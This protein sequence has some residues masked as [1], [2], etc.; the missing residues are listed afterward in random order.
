MAA[1]GNDLY[2]TPPLAVEA[3]LRAETLPQRLWEPACG[4]G[5]MVRA[6]RG[7]GFSVFSSNLIDYDTPD[8][9]AAHQDFLE[10]QAAPEGVE[11]IVTNPPFSIAALFADRAL[12]LVP[13]VYL[14][15][16]LAFLEAGTG[17]TKSSVARRKVLDGGQLAR[18]LVFK[19]RLPMMHRD[20]WDGPKST[21]QVPF[22]WFVWDRY[23]RG[24][25]TIERIGK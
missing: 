7:A 21:S 14:L 11:A 6:L 5:A 1:R 13:R 9:D 24:P 20:G 23:H 18:V 15:L 17:K 25:I 19:G 8:Q 22:A 2:E 12:E 3:L 10:Q 4:R 16:R